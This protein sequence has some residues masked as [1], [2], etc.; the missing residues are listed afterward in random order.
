[1]VLPVIDTNTIEFP[2]V[3]SIP[4]REQTRIGRAWQAYKKL[5]AVTEEKGALVP[6]GLGCKLLNVSRARF[7]VLCQEGRLDS[8][9]VEGHIFV[10][11]QSL[12][13][14]ARSERRGGRPPKLPEGAAGAWK[15]VREWQ[16]ENR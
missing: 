14:Y 8:V 6:Y 2:F 16:T 3:A 12:I 9:S 15:L 7:T 13:T 5:K 4:K 11:E 1:M 10:T